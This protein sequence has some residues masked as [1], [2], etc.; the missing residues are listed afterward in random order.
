MFQDEAPLLRAS[1]RLAAYAETRTLRPST[2]L[3]VESDGSRPSRPICY[4]AASRLDVIGR[5]ALGNMVSSAVASSWSFV[6]SWKATS[7]SLSR[8]ID[9]GAN[10]ADHKLG[11]TTRARRAVE[12]TWLS[13]CRRTS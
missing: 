2:W 5:G 11:I 7:Q 9:D 12:Y 3:F 6:G 10:P 13:R 4:A 1:T 8:E